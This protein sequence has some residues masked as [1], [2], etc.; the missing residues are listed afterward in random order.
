M[1][2]RDNHKKKNKSKSPKKQYR[3]KKMKI[4]K[5]K[6]N[7]WVLDCI[8]AEKSKLKQYRPL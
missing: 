1:T 2:S 5:E 3:M 8:N 7:L 4:K 6:E